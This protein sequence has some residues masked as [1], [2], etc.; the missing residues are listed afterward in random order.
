MAKIT[1]VG[2]DLSNND[3]GILVEG[4]ID[5]SISHAKMTGNG[6][7]IMARTVEQVLSAIEREPDE[8]KRDSY[9]T[10][11]TAILAD[12]RSWAVA[13]G[14]QKLAAAMGLGL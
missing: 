5:L 1:I 7:A 4:D 3:I 14:L 11:L 2:G 13:E 9:R 8:K 10:A 12:T 6:T